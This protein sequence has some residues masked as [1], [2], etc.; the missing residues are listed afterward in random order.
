MCDAGKILEKLL[1]LA[2]IAKSEKRIPRGQIEQSVAEYEAEMIPR[3]F[4]W[5]KKSGGDNFVVGGIY[6]GD[7]IAVLTSP[8]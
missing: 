2:E 6:L 3:A 7:Y 8:A 5:V 1:G 4:S